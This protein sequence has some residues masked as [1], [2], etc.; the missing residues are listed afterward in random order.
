MKYRPFFLRHLAPLLWTSGVCAQLLAADPVPFARD[1]SL[2]IR[3]LTKGPAG[4]PIVRISKDPRNGRLY[5]AT[6]GGSLYRL[7]LRPGTGKSVS[8]RVAGAENHGQDYLGGFDIAP[9]GDFFLVGNAHSGPENEFTAAQ[10]MRGEVVAPESEQRR[11]TLVARTE[12]YPSSKSAFDH[13]VSAL[14]V[15]PDGTTIYLN[16]GSRTD[17]GEVQSGDGAFPGVREV[18]LTTK[19]LRVPAAASG[20]VLPNNLELLIRDGRIFCEGIRNAYDLRFA[21]DGKLFGSEN[22]PDRDM[23]EELNWLREGRH[24]GFP[25]R[26]GGEDNP[27]QFPDYD[28]GTD[29]LLDGRF[30]AVR[31]G[32]FRNDPTFPPP[33]AVFTEPIRN[34][35]PDADKFRDPVS[36]VILD[37][38]DLGRTMGTLTAH[39]SPLGLVFDE[40]NVLSPPYRGDAFLASWTAGDPEG[41]GRPGPFFDSG[42]DLLHVRLKPV[43]DNFEAEIRQVVTGFLN[44]I[45]T[46][47]LGNRIIVVCYGGERS[48]WEIT[49]PA[50]ERLALADPHLGEDGFGFT[51]RGALGGPYSVERTTD[52]DYWE[53]LDSVTLDSPGGPFLDR[54]TTRSGNGVTCYYRVVPLLASEVA[55]SEP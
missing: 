33:P 6:L 25:W 4:S 32:Y 5:F 20:L 23:P 47:I 15:S 14:E 51:I 16:S 38:S 27:Q 39:R 2:Q 52:L 45:D 1:P 44:P 13:V 40:R 54:T 12:P 7:D 8:T 10:V 50:E 9:N 43:G 19:I 17:H 53:V 34:L 41:T 49:F 42:Q 35:G 3:L 21:P 11:W 55:P 46:E 48:I 29:L 28:P 18:P 22:G 37:A 36:G 26:I 31:E 24:Y 30:N